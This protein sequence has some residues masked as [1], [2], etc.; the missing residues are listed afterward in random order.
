M[1]YRKS[2]TGEVI[3]AWI[4]IDPTRSI[5]VSISVALTHD[6]ILMSSGNLVEH[7]QPVI[8]QIGGSQHNGWDE[9]YVL[10]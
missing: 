4:Q 2:L 1:R 7:E 8:E 10:Y 9:S 6:P 5:L 3:D